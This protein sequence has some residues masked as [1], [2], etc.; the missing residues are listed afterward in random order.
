MEQSTIDQMKADLASFAEKVLGDRAGSARPSE[1]APRE[2]S[3]V[4]KRRTLKDDPAYKKTT[5]VT[6][7]TIEQPQSGGYLGP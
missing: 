2:Y 3:D 1:A 5:N 4:T 7:I 6:E